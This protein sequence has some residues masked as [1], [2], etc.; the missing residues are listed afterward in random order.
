MYILYI[1][2]HM[3]ENLTLNISNMK[4]KYIVFVIFCESLRNV[5]L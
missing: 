2:S 3:Y 4:N 5:M 1:L